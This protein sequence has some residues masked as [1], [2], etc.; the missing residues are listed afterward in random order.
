MSTMVVKRHTFDIV[1]YDP[2][3][4]P[5]LPPSYSVFLQMV[6]ALESLLCLQLL[7]EEIENHVALLKRFLLV[8]AAFAL[9]LGLFA[10]MYCLEVASTHN[11]GV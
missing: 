3:S 8:V 10:A 5:S 6:D 11:F 2:N 4:I 9:A 1:A 7:V